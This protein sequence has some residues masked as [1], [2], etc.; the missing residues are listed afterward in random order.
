M[1]DDTMQAFLRRRLS[2]PNVAVKHRDL[3][4]SWSQHLE[5]ASARAAALIGAAYPQRPLHVGALLGNTPEMLNQMAAAGLGGYVLCGLNN[6]RRGAALAADV[7]RADCQ[8][9]VTDAE[10][11][12]LLDGLDLAGTQIF[13]ISTP[14]WAEFIGAAGE[15]VPHREVEA[16]D[17][18][19]MIFT[20]GT[21]GNP[22]AVQVSHLMAMFAGTNLVQ[23]FALTEQDTCYVSMPLFHSNA[24]VAGWAPAVCSGAAI[25]PA[26]FSATNFLD[27]VRNYG[28]TYMNYVGKPLAY[29][30]ATPA[31]S[32][33]ADNPLRVAF[34]NEANDKDIEEFGRRFGVQVED[35]FGSTENAVI[36]IREEGTPKGSIGKG[37]DGIAIYNSD[38]ITECAVARFDAS[39][40]LANADEAVGE[41]VNTAGSGFF[42]GYY[43]DP[44][45]NAER[46]RHGMYWSGD[47]AYRDADGWIY[48]AGR[49]ADWMRVDGENMAAA[50]IERILLRHSVINRVAVYAVPDGHVGDQVM[51]ALV[52]NEGQTLDPGEFEAFLGQQPDLSPKA[53]PRYVRIAT[54]LPSTATHKV[55]K[56]ELIAQGTAIAEG[57]TLWVREPRGTAYAERG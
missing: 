57:E 46:M 37:I 10:H 38:T 20:S 23:R 43:N 42:T 39:G 13:D 36:V 35:G 52:L 54:E 24:V 31:R 21:S 47:L 15:L 48:L 6:T 16:T 5:Q 19:M 27:D 7:R 22:K 30:L 14:Q 17:A 55:L 51:A 34:G 32:D 1:A 41:L 25:V 3:R 18:F 40:A 8:F 29:I 49:T 50:P 45:A 2:D 26:K 33:D 28:A 9:V 56:R 11:R 44:A 4:W 12:P 53:R